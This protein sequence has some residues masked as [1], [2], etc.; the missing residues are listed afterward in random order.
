MGITGFDLLK[1]ELKLQTNF[2]ILSINNFNKCLQETNKPGNYIHSRELRIE[3]WYYLQ[4][5]IVSLG[6]ISKLLNRIQGLNEPSKQKPTFNIEDYPH[7]MDRKMR[8]TLEHIDERLIALSK[9]SNVS[10]FNR[11]I[12]TSNS[13]SING[14]SLEDTDFKL[15]RTYLADKN[16]LLLYGRKFSLDETIPEL[17]KLRDEFNKEKEKNSQ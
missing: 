9:I 2:A 8:N 5:Y 4:N 6:N 10:I 7:L 13:V 12:V 11:N 17:L 16:E 14:K 3:F 1:D 15:L